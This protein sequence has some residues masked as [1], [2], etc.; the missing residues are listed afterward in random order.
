MYNDSTEEQK[1][2]IILVEDDIDVSSI[3]VGHFA[4]AKFN[5]YKTLNASE[6]LDTIKELDN[7]VDVVLIDVP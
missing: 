7:K 5:V 1:H 4:L 2:S 6:C 3:L